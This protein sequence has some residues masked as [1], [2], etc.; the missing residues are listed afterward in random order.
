MSLR[1]AANLL[2][3][4]LFALPVAIV[5]LTDK[6][7]SRCI[8]CD[9]WRYGRTH[10][11]MELVLRLA[12]ELPRSG[13]RYVLL[14]G[15]EPLLH[16]RWEE[17][18]AQ[19]KRAGLRVAMVTSGIML[20][21]FAEPVATLI[22]ELY[23]SL[24]GATPETYRAI[25]GVDGLGLIEQGAR[26]LAGRTPFAFRTTVQ[27]GNYRELPAMIRLSRAW[28][29]A[30]HSF[31]AVDVSTHAAFARREAFDASMA[32]AAEDLVEFDRVLDE[33]EREFAAEF[34]A[35][36]I[37]ESPEK[38]RR[39]RR[40]FAALLGQTAFPRVRCNAPR[41]STV[42]ETDGTLKPCY[43]LPAWGHLDGAPLSA[44]LNA[45]AVQSMRRQQ[46]L[47]LRQECARCVCFAYRSLGAML[48]RT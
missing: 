7:N 17:I 37:A 19:F 45:P 24:D 9:Y 3:D 41:F 35:G 21:R 20:P 40:Y 47:G 28:G 39:L 5:Y 6:C 32:L 2:G 15:G 48:G 31:L 25:R 18:A 8:S 29:A 10:M 13:A 4:R 36:Y 23:I 44:A 12:E 43:F 16:P 27:R 42:I 46:R 1:S 30:H 34:G 38:L 14:S 26:A 22:D 33:I 11:A